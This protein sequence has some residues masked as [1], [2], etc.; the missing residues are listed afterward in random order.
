MFL[1][2]SNPLNVPEHAFGHSEMT[3]SFGT[4]NLPLLYISEC[5][6]EARKKFRG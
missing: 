5:G 6:D 1:H 4:S 3:V 2:G